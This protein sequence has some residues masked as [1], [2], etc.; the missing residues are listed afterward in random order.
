[1]VDFCRNSYIFSF[2]FYT[3]VYVVFAVKLSRDK[4]AFSSI[5]LFFE[6]VIFW[7]VWPTGTT[8]ILL[9]EIFP[10]TS[11]AHQTNQIH[12]PRRSKSQKMSQN[13]VSLF[14]YFH[15][16]FANGYAF[17]MRYSCRKCVNLPNWIF[18]LFLESY[19]LEKTREVLPYQLS[20]GEWHMI[21]ICLAFIDVW[22]LHSP[23]VG[24]KHQVRILL[25]VLMKLTIRQRILTFHFDWHLTFL[26]WKVSFKNHI[27]FNYR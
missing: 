14:F 24:T 7:S 2:S 10:C 13:I 4:F 15:F 16:R 20:W 21:L 18:N 22:V 19:N 23:Q 8:R 6:C 9:V 11:I 3:C 26:S 1:M 12:F 27:Y 5:S 17:V 25:S